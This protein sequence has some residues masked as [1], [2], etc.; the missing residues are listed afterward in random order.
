LTTRQT[1][2]T[3]TPDE[4]DAARAKAAASRA[5][6]GFGPTI[7]DRT[8]LA[9]IAALFAA[10]PDT[11]NGGAPRSS[12]AANLPD[13]RHD[14]PEADRRLSSTKRKATTDEA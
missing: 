2:S 7:V 11:R 1:P 13:R 14:E 5:A 12:A 6:Q 8:A 4:L 10:A 3:T 9:K